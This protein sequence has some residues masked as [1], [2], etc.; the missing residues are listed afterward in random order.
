MF[1]KTWRIV[2][3]FAAITLLAAVGV[4]LA[5]RG[6]APAIDC[7]PQE[8][9]RG[10]EELIKELSL[11]SDQT[12]RLRDFRDLHH[13]QLKDLSAKQTHLQD[14][15]IAELR[16]PQPSREALN[17]II[18]AINRLQK[19]AQEGVVAH[20]LRVKEILTPSQQDIFFDIIGRRM[21]AP[22][23]EESPG[24]FLRRP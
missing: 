16:K 6:R 11:V 20:L 9:G 19:E 2:L 18:T 15:L 7:G 3:L 10:F 22:K 21:T 12:R 5:R 13:T 24:R 1:K 8:P 14:A 23:T 17:E 4:F